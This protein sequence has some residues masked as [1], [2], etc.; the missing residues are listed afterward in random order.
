MQNV[1]V[2]VNL[3]WEDSRVALSCC[4]C[5]L[6]G[7]DRGLISYWKSHTT[8]GWVSLLLRSLSL[9]SPLS[10]APL[11]VSECGTPRL[12]LR[13]GR[14]KKQKCEV[15]HTFGSCSATA[16]SFSYL[17]PGNRASFFRFR[18]SVHTPQVSIDH[19]EHMIMCRQACCRSLKKKLVKRCTAQKVIHAHAP[20]KSILYIYIYKLR[21]PSFHGMCLY[22]RRN[23]C[24]V[25]RRS[26][27]T[28]YMHRCV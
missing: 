22:A 12:T 27:C 28:H 14:A 13:H 2:S 24:S 9:A 7:L 16:V 5:L 26:C 3:L 18:S 1:H 23:P 8:D 19:R 11:L 21:G 17:S 4:Y 6:H 20:K 10:S 15:F 25:L